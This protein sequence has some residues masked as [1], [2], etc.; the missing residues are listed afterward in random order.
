VGYRLYTRQSGQAYDYTFPDC[1]GS[2]TSCTI[3]DLEDTVEYC[4]VVR[5]YNS[6]GNESSDSNEV[7]LPPTSEDP[8]NIDDDNDGLTENQGDCNDADATI[9]PG[10][11]E[12]CG[13]NVDQNCD[14]YDEH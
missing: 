6:E 10:A 1:D 13:D 12:I 3:N 11:A 5:A 9:R 4:F 8:N 7:C 2:E 14:G